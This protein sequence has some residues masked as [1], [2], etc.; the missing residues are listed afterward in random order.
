MELASEGNMTDDA[1]LRFCAEVE[2]GC[3]FVFMADEERVTDNE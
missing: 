3:L 1:L 2:D